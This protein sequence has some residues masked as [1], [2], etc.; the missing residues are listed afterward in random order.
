MEA[1]LTEACVRA[2]EPAPQKVVWALHERGRPT[3][4]DAMALERWPAAR[5][6]NVADGLCELRLTLGVR[7]TTLSDAR[8]G[9]RERLTNDNL[10]TANGAGE[11]M[12]AELPPAGRWLVRFEA[13]D[14]PLWLNGVT[15]EA[16][17]ARE[18]RSCIRD[19][20]AS[21]WRNLVDEALTEAV[22]RAEVLR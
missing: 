14:A 18:M 19:E 1:K 3:E 6:A 7:R 9:R 12:T 8:P 5:A 16:D 20:I 13:P 2:A 10:M 15:V 11:P 22:E 4:S 21:T 17:T